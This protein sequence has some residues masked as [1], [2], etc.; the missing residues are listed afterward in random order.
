MT[1]QEYSAKVEAM[2]RAKDKLPAGV[3][4]LYGQ[5][6]DDVEIRLNDLWSFGIK[7]AAQA[8]GM[9]I[10]WKYLYASTWEA[11]FTLDD[12]KV[13]QLVGEREAPHA[14]TPEKRGGET[15]MTNKQGS[16]ALNELFGVMGRLPEDADIMD[17]YAANMGLEIFLN[18]GIEEAAAA[19]GVSSVKRE[20]LKWSED[21]ERAFFQVGNVRVYTYEKKA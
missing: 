7:E 12:V 10:T 8:L 9:D 21:S 17:I 11:S 14:E 3:D 20:P 13:S 1:I 16:A 5:I 6:D 4:V 18:G 2:R 19:L 15:T